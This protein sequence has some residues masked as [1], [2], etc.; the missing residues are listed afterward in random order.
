VCEV[1]AAR[2][3]G[4]LEGGG[5]GEAGIGMRGSDRIASDYSTLISP[6]LSSCEVVLVQEHGGIGPL[7]IGDQPALMPS[8]L[9]TGRYCCICCSQEYAVQ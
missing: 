7:T 8:A 5:G 3:V 1:E 6:Y 2:R 9:W 4:K